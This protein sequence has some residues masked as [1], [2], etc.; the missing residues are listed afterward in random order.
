M[1]KIT[2]K[3][4]YT[5]KIITIRSS[6]SATIIIFLDNHRERQGFHYVSD[7]KFRQNSGKSEPDPNYYVSKIHFFTI[8]L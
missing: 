8:L 2:R 3:A 5:N 4:T 6:F 1:I 7:L